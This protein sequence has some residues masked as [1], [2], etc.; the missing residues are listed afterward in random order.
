MV[1]Y[2]D[3]GSSGYGTAV[4]GTVSGTTISYGSEYV[5][6]GA[7]TIY[8]SAISLDSTHFVVAYEDKGNSYYGT[9]VVGTVSGTTIS[10]GSEYVFNSATTQYI[11]VTALDSTHFVVSYDDNGSSDYGTAVVGTVSGTT[12]TFGSEYVFN[13]A[14]TQYISV[15]ALDSTHF[16]VAYKD[17]GNSSRGT[18]VVGT[19]SGTTISY[20]SE[21]VFNS[22]N[23]YYTLA[24]SLDSTH[25]VVAYM[26][27]GNSYYGT[28]VVGTIDGS[29]ISFGS[30]Y[31]FNSA[32]AQF[33]SGAALDSTHFVVAYQDGGNS[34]KGTT[35]VGTYAP[36]VVAPTVTTQAV[37]N[38]GT[39]TA[40]GNGTITD[41]GGDTGATR[42]MCWNTSGTPT[43]ADS[44]AT[45]GTGEG[46][47]TVAMTGL[48]AGT[49][50]YVRAYSTNSA[51][52]SYGDVVEFDTKTSGNGL[53][54]GNNF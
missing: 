48:T 38:I 9:A 22:G 14:T 53:F 5:F 20:G 42:G 49:H 34:S 10:Y 43:T 45:N 29:S 32:T 39:T 13:S 41:D 16:V 8:I 33:I 46:A 31:V 3:G 19:V 11:S 18:A 28:A 47:Y 17:V 2:N 52:T 23:T 26:D 54:F 51:G 4:V 24:I 12:I 7:D 30:E 44:H 37:T 40:T 27:G 15:T 35:V 25:C 21:Y 1:A 36:P 6:N 50:Y